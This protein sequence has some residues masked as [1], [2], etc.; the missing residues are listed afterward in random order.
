[1]KDLESC[2]NYEESWEIIEAMNAYTAGSSDDEHLTI[3]KLFLEI[4]RWILYTN[5]NLCYLVMCKKQKYGIHFEKE[6]YCNKSQAW[7]VNTKC[8]VTHRHQGAF[9][10]YT[11]SLI[12]QTALRIH[13]WNWFWI[14]G[15][16]NANTCICF[17]FVITNQPF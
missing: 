15:C 8:F 12:I 16:L 9:D 11:Q 6:S 17:H 2:L 4:Q 10:Q 3:E 5:R 7:C 13:T 1:M 14:R